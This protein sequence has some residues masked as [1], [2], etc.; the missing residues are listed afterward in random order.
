METDHAKNSKANSG[1]IESFW[2]LSKCSWIGLN[3]Q[4]YVWNWKLLETR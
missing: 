1:N 2:Y 3:R 4:I